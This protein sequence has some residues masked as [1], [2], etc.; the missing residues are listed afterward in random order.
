[1]REWRNFVK[2]CGIIAGGI[3][4]LVAIGGV[5]DWLTTAR[6]ETPVCSPQ[7]VFYPP[8]EQEYEYQRTV[9]G[10]YNRLPVDPL[11]IFGP[12]TQERGTIRIRRVP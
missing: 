3:I 2:A 8:L 5:L 1:M 12:P 7:R 9:D 10:A 4:A 6:S 11:G